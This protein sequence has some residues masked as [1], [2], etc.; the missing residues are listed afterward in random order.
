MEFKGTLKNQRYDSES[1]TYDVTFSTSSPID[2]F[3]LQDKQLTISVKQYRKKRS[4]D[5]NALLWVCLSEIAE[6]LR[7]DKWQVYL[8]MLKRYGQFQY[9]TIR[10]DAVNMFKR[11]WREC[12]V[13]NTFAGNDG[14]IY[15]NLLCYFGSST[16]DTRQFSILLDGV[17]SEMQEI[18]LETPTSEEMR[19]SL[20][21]WEKINQS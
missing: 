9:V 6:M 16:Y 12:E 20:E 18:G 11:S 3:K 13:L 7:T 5:A 2:H 19:R 21:E 15:A 4:K 14:E 10:N 8:E 1:R 17:I